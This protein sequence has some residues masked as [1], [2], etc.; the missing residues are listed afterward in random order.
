MNIDF[1]PWWKDR[2][3]RRLHK[4]R[5]IVGKYILKN[6]FILLSVINSSSMVLK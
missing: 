2:R 1:V 4:N 3:K 5:K 6:K